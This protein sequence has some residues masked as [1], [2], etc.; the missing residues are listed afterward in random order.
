MSL[1]LTILLAAV[2]FS[3]V[4]AVVR[5]ARRERAQVIDPRATRER[6]AFERIAGRL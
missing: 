5:R 4:A 6:Q 2:I 1:G 3:W